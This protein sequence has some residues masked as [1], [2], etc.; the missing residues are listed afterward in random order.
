MFPDGKII[1]VVRDPRAVLASFK[2]LTFLPGNLY[3]NVIFNWVDYVNYLQMF[4]Q[5]YSSEQI[6]IVKLED[7]H[8]DPET[9][10][11]KLVSFVE[12][13]FESAMMEPDKWPRLLNERYDKVNLSAHT[14]KKV[15]GFD[16]TRNNVWKANLTST[17]IKA[18]ELLASSALLAEGYHPRFSNGSNKSERE[19]I[20]NLFNT[21]FL[22]KNYLRLIKRGEGTQ[23]RLQSTPVTLKTGV[24]RETLLRNFQRQKNIASTALNFEN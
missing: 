9:N 13:P 20:E 7:L 24:H 22:R 18:V 14:G 12:E 15:Y 6:H 10:I 11:R 3:L 21:P 4:R 19:Q 8:L 16:P 2:S 17:E 5:M 1:F 23:T